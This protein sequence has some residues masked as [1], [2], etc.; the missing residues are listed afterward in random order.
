MPEGNVGSAEVELFGALR[1]RSRFVAA[2]FRPLQLRRH[3][4]FPLTAGLHLG[5]F[6]SF[7]VFA[8]NILCSLGW[9]LGS[10]VPRF[11]RA[12]EDPFHLA[13]GICFFPFLVIAATAR[14]RVWS[15]KVRLFRIVWQAGRNGFENVGWQPFG[16]LK[17]LRLPALG[18]MGRGSFNLSS[19]FRAIG[20]SR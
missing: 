6:I 19:T 7:L 12:R 5:Q 11:W 18:S 2:S 20:S 10:A 16:G 9:F 1:C 14:H 3:G 17:S 15:R 13:P 4:P 8:I